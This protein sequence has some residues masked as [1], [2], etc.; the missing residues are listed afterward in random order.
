MLVKSKKQKVY[1]VL[2]GGYAGRMAALRLRTRDR[3]AQIV[4]VEPSSFVVERARYHEVVGGWRRWDI[5]MH[6]ALPRGSE[7]WQGWAEAVDATN[8][9]VTARIDG[10][11]RYL[12]ADGIVVALGSRT[13][14]MDAVEAK[15]PVLGAEAPEVLG[16]V[17]RSYTVDAPLVVVGT[18]LTGIEIA[19]VL[20]ERYGAGRV[21]LVG[22][23]APGVGLSE[24]ARAYMRGFMERIGLRLV[25]GRVERV[26]GDSL[27]FVG[28][29]RLRAGAVLGCV[30]FGV[31]AFGREMGWP[32]DAQGRVLVDPS[33]ALPGAEGVFVAG[34][35]AA[36]HQGDEK[37]RMYRPACA[38]AMPMGIHA[39]EQIVRWGRGQEV[40]PFSLGYLVQCIGLGRRD[41]VL[42]FVG[43]DD[44]P[45]PR[46]WTGWRAA[47]AKEAI[48]RMTW[49]APALEK[50]LRLPVY[51]WASFRALEGKADGYTKPVV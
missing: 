28:G 26:E 33:L 44:E 3:D 1:A 30:G 32:V 23:D 15:I 21:V 39:G 18:G 6:R 41:G 42:Q 37:G 34:D 9:I 10:Q 46:F 14:G 5:P 38:T 48:L 19:T 45:T 50:W 2:G 11:V 12:E 8:R 35:L 51:R 47:W 20:A 31:S 13:L 49:Q 22:S 16:V 25:L 7:H 29:E 43:L 27:V 4:V 24:G 36:C 40:L 17:E